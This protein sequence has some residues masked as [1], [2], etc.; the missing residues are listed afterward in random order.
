MECQIY[1]KYNIKLQSMTFFR[2][3]YFVIKILLFFFI[4]FDE[5]QNWLKLDPQTYQHIETSNKHT[6]KQTTNIHR[7]KQQTY[8]EANKQYKTLFLSHP[9]HKD[10]FCCN[11]QT[12]GMRFTN[13]YI[14]SFFT[15][16]F[17]LKTKIEEM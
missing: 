17:Q 1:L 15:G 6:Y 9:F 2:K 11:L 7:N 4:N 13:F 3:I 16:N 5:M 8:I 12:T 14:D 10:L